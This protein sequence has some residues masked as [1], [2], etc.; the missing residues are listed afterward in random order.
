MK[1]KLHHGLGNRCQLK[2][3]IPPARLI[4]IADERTDG[5]V[6]FYILAGDHRIEHLRT[7]VRSAYMQG[8]HDTIDA[9]VTLK[10]IKLEQDTATASE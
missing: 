2:A 4:E 10:E 6:D 3:Y 8:V 7:L 1:R 5:M 9:A